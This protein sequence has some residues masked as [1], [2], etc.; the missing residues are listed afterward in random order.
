MEIDWVAAVLALVAGMVVAMVWYSKVGFGLVWWKLTG[1][2]PE[3]SKQASPRNLTQLLVANSVTAVGLAAG[4]AAVSEATE[5][6]SLGLALLVGLV[7]WLTFSASTLLQHNAFEL[8]PPKLTLINSSYQLVLFLAM[9]LV[10]G[11]LQ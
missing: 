5:N 6:H 10:I 3:Q 2:T 8:K 11:L 1:I 4:I 7:A 9:A